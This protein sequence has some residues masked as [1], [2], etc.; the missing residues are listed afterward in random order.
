MVVEILFKR[1]GGTLGPDHL[2]RVSL[3]DS[4]GMKQDM[5]TRYPLTRDCWLG[6]ISFQEFTIDG[7]RHDVPIGIGEAVCPA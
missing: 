2:L 3:L 4:G 7:C 5:I 1:K 6:V